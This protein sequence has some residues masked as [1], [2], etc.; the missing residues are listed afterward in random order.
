MQMSRWQDTHQLVFFY[1]CI[2]INRRP[3]PIA[4]RSPLGAGG[5]YSKYGTN[6]HFLHR[7]ESSK[8][9]T[10][11]LL[12][13][14]IMNQIQCNSFLCISIG[15]LFRSFTLDAFF[16]EQLDPIA[17]LK[18]AKFHLWLF[19]FFSKFQLHVHHIFCKIQFHC[20]KALMPI[21][22]LYIQV[23]KHKN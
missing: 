10:T 18:W 3:A 4:Y 16:Y 5:L 2:V 11:S 13:I 22:V 7:D 1:G 17:Q 23:H 8:F 19:F 14:S 12:C 6:G 20:D 21:A 9:Y 15:L